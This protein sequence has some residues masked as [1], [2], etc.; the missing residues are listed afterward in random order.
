MVGTE[1]DR[2]DTPD[3]PP[4]A[5]PARATD[6]SGLPPDEWRARGFPGADESGNMFQYRTDCEQHFTEARGHRR[7]PGGPTVHRETR[8]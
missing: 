2:Y 1:Q 6:L 8:P 4:Y 7:R 3:L 5:A